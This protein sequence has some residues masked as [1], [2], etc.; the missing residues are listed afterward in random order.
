MGARQLTARPVDE[1][2]DP[3]LGHHEVT[4]EEHADDPRHHEPLRDA[5]S[6]RP[7]LLPTL[8]IRQDR[9]PREA[10]LALGPARLV[11]IA[12]QG[13]GGAL[14]RQEHHAITDP[15]VERRSG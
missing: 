2:R 12:V 8:Q 3:P 6:L 9:P 7:V 15:R 5:T 11:Q 14:S 10:H 1:L 13:D 4:V